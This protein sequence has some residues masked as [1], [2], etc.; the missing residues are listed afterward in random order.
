MMSTYSLELPSDLLEEA[1]KLA[2]DSQVPLS[3]WVISA[4]NAQIE[5]EK[6]RRLFEDYAKKADDS[7]FDAV[8]AR[9]PDTLPVEG[10]E[11]LS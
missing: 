9:V 6:T 7:I 1:K 4:I 10:D 11:I 5:A 8:L 2:T 3:Q